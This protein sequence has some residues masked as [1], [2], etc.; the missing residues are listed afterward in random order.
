MLLLVAVPATPVAQC[1][2]ETSSS[3]AVSMRP[4]AAEGPITNYSVEADCS[5]V[6]DADGD[7]PPMSAGLDTTRVFSNLKPDTPYTFVVTATANQRQSANV[8]LTCRTL[9]GRSVVVVFVELNKCTKQ[10]FIH[11][12]RRRSRTYTSKTAKIIIQFLKCAIFWLSVYWICLY[13]SR[14]WY[15]AWYMYHKTYSA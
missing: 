5:T 11:L 12:L 15:C 10:Q 13:V 3:V 4:A 8:R 6:A 14:I 1:S 2:E 9:E 7:C